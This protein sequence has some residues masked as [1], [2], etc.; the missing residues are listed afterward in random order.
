MV[1]KRMPQAE[2]RLIARLTGQAWIRARYGDLTAAEEAATVSAL[3]GYADGRTCSLPR[4]GSL[5]ASAKADRARR[6]G[7][8]APHYAAQ[9]EPTRT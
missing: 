2:R 9:P 1:S 4:P 7:S 6:P 5:R 8:G 3:R